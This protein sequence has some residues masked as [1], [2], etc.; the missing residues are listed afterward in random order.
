MGRVGASRPGPA[1]QRLH[2]GVEEK[3]STGN[4]TVAPAP[5][6]RSSSRRLVLHV[7]LTQDVKAKSAAS[8]K[9]ANAATKKRKAGDKGVYRALV[10]VDACC[11]LTH[12][13]LLR[14]QAQVLVLV[15]APVLV[16]VTAPVP[17]LVPAR[18][19]KSAKPPTRKTNWCVTVPLCLCVSVDVELA[20][21]CDAT[22]SSHPV[23]SLQ[24]DPD[25]TSVLSLT[26]GYPL[27]KA[28]VDDWEVRSFPF[29]AVASSRAP[30]SPP[31][32]F[33]RR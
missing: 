18:R 13:W 2:H 15:Q 31:F 1:H 23:L 12:H 14:V 7:Q 8:A 24:E 20:R 25:G 9:A 22:V 28:L 3:G 19:A 17:V 10:A 33:P 21:V 29:L 32:S 27:K 30:C 6:V 5:T 16:P 4:T 26:L 11:A